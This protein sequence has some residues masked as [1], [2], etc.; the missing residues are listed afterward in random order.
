MPAA[1]EY[2]VV[3]SVKCEVHSSAPSPC[4]DYPPIERWMRISE[5]AANGF[6]KQGRI[7]GNGKSPIEV[8]EAVDVML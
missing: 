4:K 1:V 8:V 5:S 6:F 7:F 3:Y 2:C